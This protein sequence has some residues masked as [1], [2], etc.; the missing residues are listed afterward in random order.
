MALERMNCDRYKLV[1]FPY[2]VDLDFFTPIDKSRN[3]RL[4]NRLIF[5]SSGRLVN[6]HK[7]YDLAIGALGIVKERMLNERFLYKVAGVGP[8]KGALESLAKEVGISENLELV[9]WL[10]PEALPNFYRA[11]DVFLHPAPFDPYGNSVL[12]AM[13]CGVPVIGSDQVGSVID[14][15]RHM[16]NGIVHRAKDIEDLARKIIDILS[17][18]E[19]LGTLGAEARKTAELWPVSRGIETI[20][21]MVA[22]VS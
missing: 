1:N 10:E 12:E 22:N 20:K 8:D 7:G 11:G 9:G 5:L 19:T 2:F 4:N 13:A 6:S 15:I 14:R 17:C 16:K 3:K 18:S 21:L